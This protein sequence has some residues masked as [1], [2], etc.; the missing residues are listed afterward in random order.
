MYGVF[1]ACVSVFF[2]FLS[3]FIYKKIKGDLGD[4]VVIIINILM[5]RITYYVVDMHITSYIFLVKFM[6]NFIFFNL[7]I[8]IPTLQKNTIIEIFYLTLVSYIYIYYHIIIQKNIFTF[9]IYQRL[10]HFQQN[11][12]LHHHLVQYYQ[13]MCCYWIIQ[14]YGDYFLSDY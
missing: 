6:H 14:C 3:F 4:V 8:I 2:C 7:L 11:Q 1:V 9:D 10:Q 13:H 12:I 5:M